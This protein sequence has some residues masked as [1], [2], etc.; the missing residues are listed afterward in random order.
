MPADSI[1]FVTMTVAVFLVAMGAIA[2]AQS[3]YKE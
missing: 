3:T 2:Y 1:L